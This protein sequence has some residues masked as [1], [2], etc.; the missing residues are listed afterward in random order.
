MSGVSERANG[1]ASGPVL[2]SVFLVVL[3]HSGRAREGREE[4]KEMEEEDK[5]KDYMRRKEKNWR[6][7][8]WRRKK[9]PRGYIICN[10]FIVTRC[11]IVCDVL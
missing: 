10:Y 6:K 8:R 9:V 2:Q 7:R 5:K 4:V 11:T 3:A 1:R